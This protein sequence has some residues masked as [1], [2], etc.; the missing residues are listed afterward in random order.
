MAHDVRPISVQCNAGDHGKVCQYKDCCCECHLP[1]ERQSVRW[2][3]EQLTKSTPPD[4]ERLQ[5]LIHLT[6]ELAADKR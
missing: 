5:V 6:A 2:R 4:S 1:Q 3:L